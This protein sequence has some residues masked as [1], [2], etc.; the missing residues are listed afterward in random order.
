MKFGHFRRNFGQECAAAAQARQASE[1]Q[2]ALEGRCEEL[3]RAAA[4][5]CGSIA[6]ECARIRHCRIPSCCWIGDPDVSYSTSTA[7]PASA[8]G[9]VQAP[10]A[11]PAV[12]TKEVEQK[13]PARCKTKQE[14]ID[15]ERVSIAALNQLSGLD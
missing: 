3:E 12:V 2:A 10:A 14:W 8:R 13:P 1:A 4:Q 6:L 7:A 15:A 5:L 11:A 9:D